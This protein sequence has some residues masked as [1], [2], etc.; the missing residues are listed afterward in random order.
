M[1]SPAELAAKRLAQDLGSRGSVELRVR[2]KITRHE[3]DPSKAQAFDAVEEHYVEAAGRRFC[4]VRSVQ[5]GA[6]VNRSIYYGDG[7][8][9]A[10]VVYDPK[11]IELQQ[12]VYL[13]RKSWMDAPAERDQRPQPFLF[14]SVGREPLPQALPKAQYLGRGEVIGRECDLF[15]FRNVRWALPQDQVFFLD[16]QTAIPLKVESYRDQ[17]AREKG[18]AM[19][20]WTATSLDDVRG[21]HVPL[22]STLSAPGP[23]GRPLFTWEYAVESIEFGKDYPASMFW[24]TIQPGVTVSDA[25]ADKTYAAPGVKEV[26][27]TSKEAKTAARP[28]QAVPTLEWSTFT[29]NWAFWLG[30]LCIATAVIAWW[31]RR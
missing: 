1:E 4:E 31:R 20:V 24:P 3:P 23:E 28:I 26:A 29:T 14:L 5:S 21:H 25:E 9:Y 13:N 8:K 30:C 12:T 7:S 17:A 6:V 10:F 19:A 15:L 11:D 18:E 2:T 27:T 22:H 16:N